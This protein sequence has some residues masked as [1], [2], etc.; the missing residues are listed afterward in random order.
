MRQLLPKVNRIIGAGEVGG[1]GGGGGKT[2]FAPPPPKKKGE[3]G[4]RKKIHKLN[5]LILTLKKQIYASIFRFR[6][7]LRARTDYLSCMSPT[8]VARGGGGAR[9]GGTGAIAPTNMLFGHVSYGGD[10]LRY[11][12]QI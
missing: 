3:E 6:R 9:G 5:L 4:E 1:G 2:R 8:S 10:P 7:A 12:H 11:K